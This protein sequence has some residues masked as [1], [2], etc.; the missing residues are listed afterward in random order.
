MCSPG[1]IT[2]ANSQIERT[3]VVSTS[4]LAIDVEVI[5][6]HLGSALPNADSPGGQSSDGNLSCLVDTNGIKI[7]SLESET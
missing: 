6:S 7:E 3:E 5:L 2:F 1:N 4:N